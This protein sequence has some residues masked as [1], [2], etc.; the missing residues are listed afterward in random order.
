MQNQPKIMLVAGEASGDLH[1]AI[2]S[3]E[4]KQLI[5]DAQLIGMGG[6]RMAEAGV[7]LVT[8]ISHLAVCGGVEVIRY[9]PKILAIFTLV[10]KTLIQQKPDLLILIDYPTFNLRMAKVAKKLGVKVLYYISPQ[11]WAWHTSRVKKIKKSVDMMAVVFPFE[12]E[13]YRKYSVPVKYVGHP[14]VKNIDASAIRQSAS[15]QFAMNSD[16]ITV[17]LLPGSRQNEIFYLLPVLLE[18]AQLL[19]QRIPNLHFILPLAS[20]I[21]LE[22]INPFL[23][24]TQLPLTVVPHHSYEA[25]SICQA[26]VAASGTVNLELALLGVPMV[27]VYKVNKITFAIGKRLIK[28]PYLSI[29]NVIAGKK[30]VPE[31]LQNEAQPELIANELQHLLQDLDYRQAQI[32]QLALVANK[33]RAEKECTAADLAYQILNNQDMSEVSLK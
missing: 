22:D 32:E 6:R 33:L 21:T 11:I 10:K 14:L 9:L 26:V 30:I 29:C 18:T 15:K 24:N 3:R 31:L 5:P 23:K 1:G 16:K 2:L 12:A 17:G 28:I 20:T 4:I 19:Q 13:F 8:D 7:E 25:M 27:V